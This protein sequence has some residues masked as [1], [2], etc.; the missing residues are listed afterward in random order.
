[1]GKI[2][3]KSTQGQKSN[4]KIGWTSCIFYALNTWQKSHKGQLQRRVQPRKLVVT[5]VNSI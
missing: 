5:I 2:T 1:M 4:W 3:G